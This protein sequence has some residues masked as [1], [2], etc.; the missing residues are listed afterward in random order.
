MYNQYSLLSCEPTPTEATSTSQRVTSHT[1]THN[2]HLQF[3]CIINQHSLLV[4]FSKAT[5]L[6]EPNSTVGAAKRSAAW[7]WPLHL[8][9]MMAP[10]PGKANRRNFRQ[11][12]HVHAA[13]AVAILNTL[14]CPPDAGVLQEKADQVQPK[15]EQ[16][17]GPYLTALAVV[18]V[19]DES[20]VDGVV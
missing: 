2:T 1:Y 9:T 20:I 19:E 6:A 10:T 13:G 8:H 14:A 15:L 16:V 17:R 12:A 11:A 7:V 3:E 18:L 4:E 5:D